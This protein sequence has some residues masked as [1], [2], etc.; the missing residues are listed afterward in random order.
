MAYRVADADL[1]QPM[2]MSGVPHSGGQIIDEW[3]RGLQGSQRAA[4]V[5]REMR[6]SALPGTFVTILRL[7][8]GSVTIDVE[9]PEGME[10]DAEALRQ[11][12][13]WRDELSRL[14]TPISDVVQEIVEGATTYGVHL[15]EPIV[16]YEGGLWR[17]YDLE[18]R[19]GDTVYQWRFD[20]RDRAV[21]VQQRVRDGRTAWLDLS[22]VVHCPIPTMTRSPEG[23]SLFRSGWSEWMQGRDLAVDEAI[24]VGRDLTGVPVIEVPRRVMDPDD[25]DGARIRREYEAIGAKLRA[26][27][28]AYVLMPA[29]EERGEKSGYSI[30]LMTSGGTQRVVADTPIRR[31]ESR[32]MISLLTE[33][34][35]LGDGG[36]P[37]GSRAL[38]DP[39]MELSRRC[40]GSLIDLALS[41]LSYQWIAR[42]TRWEGRDDRYAPRLTHSDL[43][44]PTIAELTGLLTQAATAGLVTPTDELSRYILGQIPGAPVS[45]PTERIVPSGTST[46]DPITETLAP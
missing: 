46:L 41:R 10:N 24:G 7:V 32:L 39:K 8:A 17:T 30:R 13:R 5:Y 37:G 19:G 44:P 29:A 36:G 14:E 38:A 2:G 6:D 40:M 9:T 18:P 16:R 22:R 12:D 23:R 20:G 25:T 35:L 34:A 1:S 3:A 45:E 31:H 43:S 11:R 4:E 15:V 26:G 21:A 28:T 27:R 33:Y 42:L